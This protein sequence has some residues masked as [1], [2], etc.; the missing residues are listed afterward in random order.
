MENSKYLRRKKAEA[1]PIHQAVYQLASEDIVDRGV[2]EKIDL[3]KR[4]HFEAVA[5]SIRWDYISGWIEA[6]LKCELVPLVSRYFR[7]H[8]Q[9]DVQDNPAEYIA[10]GH[11]K[12][13]MGYGAVGFNE[14]LNSIYIHRAK[15]RAAVTNGVGKAFRAYMSEV[16]KRGLELPTDLSLLPS[17]D[18][19]EAGEQHAQ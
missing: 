16:E 7:R 2:F 12:K 8:R 18:P 1:C 6:E 5:G 15:Q 17:G 4:L 14:L 11:G 3:L 19:P 10:S 9:A 13:T